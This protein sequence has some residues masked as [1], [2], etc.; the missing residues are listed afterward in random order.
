MKDNIKEALKILIILICISILLSIQEAVTAQ[1]EIRFTRTS[2]KVDPETGEITYS[3]TKITAGGTGGIVIIHESGIIGEK[4]T[5]SNPSLIY[6]NYYNYNTSVYH[7]SDNDV[8]EFT[9]FIIVMIFLILLIVVILQT[10][11]KKT[12]KKKEEKEFQIEK[13]NQRRTRFFYHF[14]SP[15]QRR[16]PCNY[17]KALAKKIKYKLKIKNHKSISQKEL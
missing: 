2:K 17:G 11:E 7:H 8:A 15:I 1:T 3:K 10:L 12:Q 9:E 6:Y 14:S 4:H 16:I 13:E 5:N